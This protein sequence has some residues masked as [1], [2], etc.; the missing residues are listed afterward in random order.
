MSNFQTISSFLS[1][2]FGN[3][4]PD[5]NVEYEKDYQN[6]KMKKTICID[7]STQIDGSF[8]VHVK[9]PSTTNDGYFYDVV[10]Q[11]FTDNSS[12]INKEPTLKNYFVKFFSNSP[13]FIYHYASLYKLNGFLINELFE[14]LDSNTIDKLPEKTNK[15]MQLSYDKSIYMACRLLTDDNGK[16]LYKFGGMRLKN[17]NITKF[18]SSISSFENIR[19]DSDMQN[20]DR[21]IQKQIDSSSNGSKPKVEVSSSY[22]K[23]KI[24]AQSS[25]LSTASKPGITVHS[26]VK[27]GLGNSQKRSSMV[28]P[29][30][31]SK[32]STRKI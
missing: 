24:S 31:T 30:K 32:K 5:K 18:L 9:V 17:K 16:L 23:M 3:S 25:T 19:V 20:M 26:K 12:M 1:K 15:G 2:P 10:L 14:K 22:G 11:F 28:V 8:L 21:K 27:A 29:K 7:G 6:A 4:V 13:G